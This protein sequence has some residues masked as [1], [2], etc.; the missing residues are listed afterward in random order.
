[1]SSGDSVGTLSRILQTLESELSASSAR[2]KVVLKKLIEDVSRVRETEVL[3]Q[4]PTYSFLATLGRECTISEAISRLRENGG[5]IYAFDRYFICDDVEA[6]IENYR[7]KEP[8]LDD[9]CIYRVMFTESQQNFAL[10]LHSKDQEIIRVITD[11]IKEVLKKAHVWLV[12]VDATKV[13]YISA[14]VEG[15]YDENAEFFKSVI[16]DLHSKGRAD[17]LGLVKFLEQYTDSV[18]G[19]T[20]SHHIIP[21]RIYEDALGRQPPT[22]YKINIRN[23]QIGQIIGSITGS[24]N[25]VTGAGVMNR[26]TEDTDDDL[27]IEDIVEEKK[28]T[29]SIR[30]WLNTEPNLDKTVS[31]VRADYIRFTRKEISRAAFN[32][33][34]KNNGY[35]IVRTKT[36][37]KFIS[38]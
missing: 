37:N 34:M 10:I 23:L 17:L 24:D 22:S 16:M 8:I 35:I 1:M 3:L 2:A 19:K 27:D 7:I 28:Q 4:N 12:P 15:T 20:F 21:R 31:Y 25:H 6:V 5:I 13:G 32:S 11:S 36:G 9:T 29:N 26:Q 38:R 33:L 30:R 18:S 14:E